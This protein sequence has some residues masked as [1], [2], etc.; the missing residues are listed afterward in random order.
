[1]FLYVCGALFLVG[2]AIGVFAELTAP[3]GSMG[4]AIALLA[5]GA[6]FVYLGYLMRKKKKSNLSATLAIRQQR[7]A[8]A[9]A[10][11]EL[12]TIPYPMGV[13]LRPGERC[14]FQS[15]A[16]V[17]VIKNQVVGRTGGSGGMSV[18]VAK[19]VT[20]HSG[21]SASRTIREDVP[22]KYPGVFSVTDQRFIMTGEKAFEYPIDKLA[23]I[24]PYNG[25]EGVTLQFGRSSYTLLMDESFWIP[26][27]IDLI[28]ASKDNE[29]ER[30]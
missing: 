27:M 7:I 3:S 10:L 8:E 23:S 12:P 6:L 1:M 18:R 2:G 21:R 15:P 22:Y 5:L 29:Q 14:C 4:L 17:L 19:G 16:V 26:K 13:M 28:N 24:L 9:Q 20:L 25:Y 11:T 30:V